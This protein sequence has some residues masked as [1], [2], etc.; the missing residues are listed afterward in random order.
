MKSK[1]IDIGGREV[2]IMELSFND[3]L[4]LEEK[5]LSMREV[6]KLSLGEDFDLKSVTA[7]EGEL[8]IK[9]INALNNLQIPGLVE[10]KAK[11]NNGN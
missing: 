4:R 10:L 11:L 5:S 2:T 9:E 3:K 8:I 1:E 7:E 6:A